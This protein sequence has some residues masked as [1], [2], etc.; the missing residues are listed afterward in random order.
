MAEG[1]FMG[2]GLFIT[3][4]DTGVGKTFIGGLLAGL[5]RRRGMDVGVMKPVES[6]C[7]R[8][9]G[10]LYPQDAYELRE[11]AQSLD[12]LTDIVLYALEMPAA[13]AVAAEKE[14]IT[15]QLQAIVEKFQALSARHQL[16]IVEGA[17]GLLVPLTRREDN[18]HL[19]LALNVPVLVVARASLGT[20]NHTL[21]T[22][23][24]AKALGIQILGVVINDPMGNLSQT[25][26]ENLQALVERLPVPLLGIVP[27][28][29][30]SFHEVLDRV[31]P[32]LDLNQFLVL[33]RR[34]ETGT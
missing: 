5:L 31:E 15:I 19:I 7:L 3:G 21:L 32:A 34:P 9:D 17:G 18:T 10:A 20:I 12:P 24:W 23:N 33:L 1:F 22:I 25:E 28:L 27:H 26:R 11:K 14:G 13:P 2:T 4:T 6:G 8:R 16:T 30:L 29:P